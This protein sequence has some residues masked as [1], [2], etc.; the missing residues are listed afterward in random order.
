[1]ATW[2]KTLSHEIAEKYLDTPSIREI[3]I[4][5]D[6]TNANHRI[7]GISNED[8]M[9]TEGERDYDIRFHAV[10]PA[11]NEPIKLIINLEAQNKQNPGYPILKRAIYQGSR[12]ISA[13]YGVEFSGSDFKNLKKVYS[14]WV[15]PSP[16][17]SEQN[18][19]ERYSIVR[20]IIEGARKEAIQNYDLM[21]IVMVYLGDPQKPSGVKII[22]LLSVLLSNEL[23]AEVKLK[24]LETEYGISVTYRIKEEVLKMCNLSD[25]IEQ[26]GIDVQAKIIEGF[27][28]K[29][30]ISL[31]EALKIPELSEKK[32][33][34]V[35]TPIVDC[36]HER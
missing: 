4:F 10:A 6:E 18:V 21:T 35:A 29:L 13:Q 31:D 16:N 12:L 15:L 34:S 24:T 19:I 14:I 22:D 11:L 30:N 2:R 36:F 27:M 7:S 5:P 17:K 8:K 3:P 26:K 23:D 32:R 33:N 28:R 20:D 9:D 1:M 25:A